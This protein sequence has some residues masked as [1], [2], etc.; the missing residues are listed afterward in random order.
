MMVVDGDK[1]TLDGSETD[2]AGLQEYAN[3]MIINEANIKR[4]YFILNEGVMLS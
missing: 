3:E 2:P 1:I 4:I